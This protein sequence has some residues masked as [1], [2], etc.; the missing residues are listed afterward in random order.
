MKEKESHATG[1]S[2][3]PAESE[4]QMT[5]S[6][7]GVFLMRG[8]GQSW[9]EFKKVCIQRLIDAKQ[10]KILRQKARRTRGKLF[11]DVFVDHGE[12]AVKATIPGAFKY[13]DGIN[14]GGYIG[15]EK[16]GEARGEGYQ[17]AID[18]AGISSEVGDIDVPRAKARA[19]KASYAEQ[20]NITRRGAETGRV[21][22]AG[23]P[24]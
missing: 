14:I 16:E 6:K 21:Q 13:F 9:E 10:G 15:R 1:Q 19:I 20:Y 2:D 23:S 17:R 5:A 3:Q 11:N 7:K 8:K 4:Q 22:V 24:G 18:N 12:A